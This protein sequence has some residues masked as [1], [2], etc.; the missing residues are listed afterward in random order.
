MSSRERAWV[1]E[2]QQAGRIRPEDKVLLVHAARGQVLTIAR[3]RAITGWDSVAARASLQRLRDADLL[4]QEGERAGARYHLRQGLVPQAAS[5]LTRA[6]IEDVVL[7]MAADG[8][9][10]NESARESTSL[11][12]AQALTV[13]QGLVEDG[14]LV[15]IGERRGARYVRP[16]DAGDQA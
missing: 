3:V 14:R 7:R 9:V 4:R 12:R 15:M 1:A 8:P 13:L 11:D 10:T 5:P 6:E 16:Q 2:I